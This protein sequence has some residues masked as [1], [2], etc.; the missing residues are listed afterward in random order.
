MPAFALDLDHD[1]IRLLRKADD[2]WLVADQVA[3]DDPKLPKRLREMRIAA[4]LQSEGPLETELII[5]PSQILYTRVPAPEN[6]ARISDED[7][8]S[9]LDGLTPCPAEELV[10]DWRRDGD[11]ICVAALDINTLD[12]A[13]SFATTYGFNP[14]RFAARPDTEDFP[15]TPD[16]GAT[17]FA[18]RQP[19]FEDGPAFV[20]QRPQEEATDEAPA[21]VPPVSE[22]SEPEPDPKPEPSADPEPAVAEEPAPEPAPLAET[23]TEAE[24]EKETEDEPAPALVAPPRPA[25]TRRAPAQTATIALRRPSGSSIATATGALLTIGLLIW[26]A[27]YLVTPKVDTRLPQVAATPAPTPESEEVP[28]ERPTPRRLAPVLTRLEPLPP[29]PSAEEAPGPGDE[30]EARSTLALLAPETPDPATEVGVLKSADV[31]QKPLSAMVEPIE[32]LLDDL[33]VASIDPVVSADDAFALAAPATSDKPLSEQFLPPQ[34]GDVFDLDEDGLVA[35][36]PEGA[37]TPDGAFVIAGTPS[38]VPPPRPT[39]AIETAQA[40]VA[41]ALAGKIPRRRPADLV[42]RSERAQLGGRTKQELSGI[43]PRP[44]PASAQIEA[45]I[46]AALQG[47]TSPSPLAVAVSRAPSRRPANFAAAVAAQQAARGLVTEERSAIVSA[48]V[49]PRQPRIPS[50]ASVSRQATI[51][52]A[53]NLRKLNLI[54]VYGSASDRR[55]LLRLPSGRYVKVKVGD[56]IDGGQVG[57][58]GDNELRY[59]KGG[60]NVTLTVPSG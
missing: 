27:L 45:A 2:D 28:T 1:G 49:A 7:V 24:T 21:E 15:D 31:W 33:Y 40:E 29:F 46:E 50:S 16:F 55:A 11:E 3:L 59:I 60:R 56:R 17:Q 52:N 37:M 8:L 23:E 47:E 12:E 43:R 20:S 54:G 39:V 30:M 10:I 34:L 18:K 26:T 22:V 6:A 5:P 25:P 51:E 44:R 36:T 32:S 19:L 53:I 48:S 58:I 4:E 57:A 38:K 13:E 14:M 42:E 9:R 41:L 35:A